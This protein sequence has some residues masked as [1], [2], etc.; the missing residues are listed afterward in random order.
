MPLAHMAALWLVVS[1]T[2]QVQSHL[3]AFQQPDSLLCELIPQ[4]QDKD[5]RPTGHLLIFK[6]YNK[7][8]KSTMLDLFKR[9]IWRSLG[10]NE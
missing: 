8:N 2:G 7:T 6:F 5:Q 9:L 4:I 1:R 10:I 3:T